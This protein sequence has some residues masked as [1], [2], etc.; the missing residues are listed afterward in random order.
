MTIQHLGFAD[1]PDTDRPQPAVSL[2]AAVLDVIVHPSS[3]A[4]AVTTVVPAIPAGIPAPQFD[5]FTYGR[6][7]AYGSNITQAWRYS[8]GAGVAVGLVDDG[9]DPAT[10]ATFGNFSTTLSRAFSGT[11]SVAEPA[12]GYHG[13][14]TSGLIG[15][16]GADGT[17]EGLAPNV[18]IVGAKVTFTSATAAILAQAEGYDASLCSVVNNSWGYTGYGVGEPDSPGF[19]IWFSAVGTAVADGRHGLGDVI[20]FSAGNDRQDDNNLAVQPIVADYRVI[21]VAATD[22]DGLVAS[23][24]TPGAALLVSAIGDNV[25]VV[26]TGGSGASAVSGT[27]YS[28]PTVAAIAAMM[29]SV[30]PNLGWRDVQEILADSSYVPPPSAGSFTYNGATDWNG[31]GMHFSNNLGYG[32][33]DANV[34]VNLARAWTEQSTSA[35]LDTATVGHTAGVT[36]G[37]NATVSSTVADAANIR[38]QHVEVTINDTYLPVAWSKVVLVSPDGTQSVLVDQI[39]LVSD[40]DQTQGLDVSGSVITSNAFWGETAAGTWTLQVQDIG[41]KVVGTID[42]WSLTFI[43]DNAATVQTLLVYTPEFASIATA[44]REVVTSGTSTTVDLIALPGRTTINLNGGAGLIGGVNVSVGTGLTNANADGSTGAVTLTGL[45]NG[46]SELTGGDGVS[47]LLGS[48]GDSINA[49]LGTTTIR[50]GAGGSTVTLSSVAA[51]TVTVSSGGGD[52]I[53]AGLATAAVTN[54]GTDGDTI[55]DQSATLSFFNGNGASEVNTGTGTVMVQAGAGGGTYY[56]GSAGNSHLIAGTGLVTFYG[57][58]SGDLLTAAGSPADTLIAGA[59]AETLSGGSA[60][61]SITLQA[62]SGAD[63]MIAGKGNTTFIVGSGNSSITLGGTGGLIQ[64]QSG[65]AGGLDTVTAFQVGLDDLH[66]VNF[67]ALAMR[68]AITRDKS[69]GHGG[70]LVTFSDDTRIDLLGITKVTSSDFG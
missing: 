65:H 14:T 5:G 64:I 39:G 40:T 67:A 15:A 42:N 13:T 37:K 28:A 32:V 24:S 70:T 44:P 55:Y 48:G 46:G 17:P 30:N 45:T 54:I 2:A 22:A 33:V 6:S 59:G 23:Y 21:A 26:D 7:F 10:T 36:V 35:N 1:E 52:T 9:F 43:G 58:V 31:G 18:T 68:S 29:L 38:I 8:S 60:T 41:G 57:E 62:G 25:A 20:T 61:G 53:Y 34:A 19:G 50:T 51:S 47:T 49:G 12:G 27:S 69:D 56:A 11:S 63:T 3:P 66:L 16:T 4:A